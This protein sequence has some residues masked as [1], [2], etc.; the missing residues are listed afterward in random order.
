[1]AIFFADFCGKIRLFSL[2]VPAARL[3]AQQLLFRQDVHSTFNALLHHRASDFIRIIDVAIEM[4]VVCVATTR[5]N[6]LCKAIIA[7]FTREQ[8]G[9]FE[10]F[11]NIRSL[12]PRKYA[13]HTEF[14]VD[15]KLMTGV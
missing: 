12:N 15:C 10:L 1:M 2:F 4:I 5:T 14:F 3:F 11:T 7:L 13:A 8:A 9:I 6:E